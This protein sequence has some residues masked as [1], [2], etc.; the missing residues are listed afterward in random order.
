MENIT[1]RSQGKLI[2]RRKD[3]DTLANKNRTKAHEVKKLSHKK[4]AINKIHKER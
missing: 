2:N 1:G 4:Q 3:D